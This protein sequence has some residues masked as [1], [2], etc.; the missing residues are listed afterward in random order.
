MKI[1]RWKRESGFIGELLKGAPEIDREFRIGGEEF[2]GRQKKLFSELQKFGFG[3]GIVYS[4]EH[5]NGDFPYLGGNTN[6]SV[7]PVAGVIGNNGF[8]ILAGLEGGYV[9]EQLSP[10]SGAKVHKVEMLKLADEDYPIDAER[11]EDVI[12]EAAGGRPDVIALLTPRE[13]FPVSIYEFLAAYL[14]G[15]DR[16]VDAQEVY[17]KIKYEK[18]DVEMR[19]IEEASLLADVMIEGMLGVLKPGMYE[20]QVAAWGYAIAFELGMEEMGFDLMVTSGEA[21][22]TLVGK[23]L[24]RKIREGDFVHVGVGPKRDGLTTCER[25][26]IVAVNN[27]SKI[28]DDQRFWLEFVEEA[29]QVGLD[30]YRNVA[31]KALPAKLQ[32]QALVDYFKRRE[33][34]VNEKFGISID[35]VRQKPYTGTHNA[36]YTEC[37]EFYGAITLSSENPL[38]NQI[39]TMLDVAVRGV[40]NRW[41]NVLIPGLDY[42]L[43]EKTL[44]KFGQEVRVLNR[45]PVRVQH[46]VGKA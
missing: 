39:V 10:R 32:E 14:G 40:G 36:G 24:N 38:G 37:Q 13:V 26:S 43:V 34:E 2:I 18:S 6:I 9:A 25:V 31:K 45:L 1:E 17:Y 41:N 15:R 30:A 29:F 46:L 16:I 19:L 21:N 20:T 33:K 28:T 27:P 42:V 44:G 7:E 8:H 11:V 3:C 35:L 22:R 12:E 23:A 4:D 5:Y